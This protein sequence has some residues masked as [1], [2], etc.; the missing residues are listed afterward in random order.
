MAGDRLV[1]RRP[2]RMTDWLRQESLSHFSA[3]LLDVCNQSSPLASRDGDHEQAFCPRS[4][5]VQLS[6]AFGALYMLPRCEVVDDVFAG[7]GA[8]H[9]AHPWKFHAL[10]GMNGSCAQ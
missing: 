6:S 8:K 7:G 3:R 9:Y 5:N 4:C 1:L 2:L 10:Y